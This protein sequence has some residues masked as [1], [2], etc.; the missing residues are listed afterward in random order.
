MGVGWLGESGCGWV[1]GG[2][3]R[4]GVGGYG[5]EGERVFGSENRNETS[6]RFENI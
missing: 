3:V 5:Q 1:W 2:W 6:K 4:V